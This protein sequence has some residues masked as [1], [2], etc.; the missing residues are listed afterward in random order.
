MRFN[1]MALSGVVALALSASASQAAILFDNGP[2]VDESG[3]SILA[4]T[5]ATLGFSSTSSFVMADN[6]SVTGGSWNV[7]SIDFY[8][9]QTGA[10]GFTFTGATWSIISGVDV[11]AGAIVASG[12]TSVTN[13]GLVGYRVT[14]T[15]T[16][17]TARAIYRLNADIS[18]LVLA[19]GSYFLTWSLA[20]NGGSGPFVPP[21]LGSLG[22]GNALQA[23]TGGTFATTAD[24]GSGQSVDVPFTINGTL[25]EATVPE[26]ATWGMMILGFGMIGGAARYRQRSVKAAV[27]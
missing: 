7:S 10:A 22:I 24:A 20:G 25:A 8:G 13:A 18:D 27:A 21:V 16:T 11:N 23:P 19:S 1:Y 5:A 2:I 26:P 9:Y 4:P 14:G 12:T 17:S 6:F 15:T 3:L